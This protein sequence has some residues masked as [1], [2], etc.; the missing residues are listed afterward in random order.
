VSGADPPGDDER[1]RQQAIEES[2]NEALG[3]LERMLQRHRGAGPDAG[4][5]NPAGDDDEHYSV[6][7]LEE[8]VVPGVPMPAVDP[9]PA[10]EGIASGA[11]DDEPAIRR[12]LATRIASEIEVI[13]QDRLEAALETARD[14]IRHQVRNHLDIILPE[15]VDELMQA[16][17]RG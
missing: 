14:E 7:L 12:R 13:V 6:P 11:E 3:D 4:G 9:R 10:P 8:V 2:L 15:L 17:R 5:D 1:A 16:R